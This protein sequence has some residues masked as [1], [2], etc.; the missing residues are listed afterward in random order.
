LTGFVVPKLD[1][2]AC[3]ERVVRY[4]RDP[5]L[6]RR[7]GAAGQQRVRAHFAASDMVTRYEALYADALG[8]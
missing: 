6:A 2:R 3:A 7:L 1:A 5:E 8:V 4:L